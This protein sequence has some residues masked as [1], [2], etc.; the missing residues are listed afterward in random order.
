MVRTQIA[1]VVATIAAIE[2]PR[3]Q[4]EELLP[5]LCSS[6]EHHDPNVRL[7]SLTTLGY[8]CEEIEVT[9]VIDPVKNKIISALIN[10]IVLDGQSVSETCK[11][12]VKSLSKSVP[13]AA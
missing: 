6:A 11:I 1:N 7:S 9:D 2:I 8:I 10:N 13:F 3:K 5:D 12:A 4:W